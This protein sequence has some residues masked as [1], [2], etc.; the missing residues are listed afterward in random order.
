MRFHLV[1]TNKFKT[2]E[3]EDRFLYDFSNMGIKDPKPITSADTINSANTNILPVGD[4][5][6]VLWEAGSA[7]SMDPETLETLTIEGQT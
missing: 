1:Q 7:H 6:W 2:E 3:L 5:I 4:D